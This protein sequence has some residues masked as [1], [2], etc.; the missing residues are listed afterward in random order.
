MEWS[1]LKGV[2]Y[3]LNRTG[4]AVAGVPNRV[5]VDATLPTNTNPGA[6]IFLFSVHSQM[7]LLSKE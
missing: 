4:R 1:L 2:G 3:F 5:P 6:Q 7:G